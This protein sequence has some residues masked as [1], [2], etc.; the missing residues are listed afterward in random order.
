MVHGDVLLASSFVSYVGPFNK[1]FRDM[2]INDNFLKFFKDNDIPMSPKCDPLDILCDAAEVAQWNNEK[3][4]SDRVSTENGAI[5]TNSDRYSLIIDPQLQG[6][7]WLKEREKTNDLRVTRLSNPKMVKILEAAIE[8]GNP[9]MI[10]NLE[11]NIDAVIQP[12]YARAIIKRGKSKYIKMG[13]KELSLHNDFNLYLHTKLQS[14]HY[15]PEIQAECTLI[16]FTVTE[17]GLEDQLLAL[18]VKKE[19]PDLA[20]QKD[21]LIQDL[22]GY[23]IKL[24]NLQASLLK[25]LADQKGDILDDIALIESLEDA[26]KVSTE[27]TEKVAIAEVIQAQILE[28]SE[29]YRPAAN[30]GALVFFLMNE[31]N[32][33]HSFYRFS[34]DSFVIV[35]NRAIDIVAD[36]LNP[37]KQKKLDED[38]EEKAEGEEGAEAEAEAEEEEEE[39]EEQEMTPRTL[40]KRV[41]MILESI[42]FEGFS[43]TR[44]GTFEAHK[45]VVATMLTL[46]INVR[47][48]LIKENEVVALIKKEVALEP[49]PMPDNLG[50]F[51]PEAI[52]PAV[53]GLQSVKL[54]ENLVSSMESESLQWKKWYGDEKAE[55]AELP[56]SFKDIS[57]FHRILLLRALRPDRLN[58]A[59]TQYVTES[60]GIDYIEQPSFDMQIVYDEMSV[61]TP[62]FFVLFPGVDPTNDVE[63]VGAKYGKKADDQTFT[64]IS[65]GQGQEQIALNALKSAATN[66]N[67]LMIQNVHLMTD[68]M[69]EFERA[70]EVAVD[71]DPH[72]DFRCF[73]SSEPPGLPQQ[74]II[75]E[76]ILQNSIKVSNQAPQDLKANLRR[77]MSKFDEE[78]YE[79]AKTHKYVEFKAIIFGLIMFHALILGRRK[80]GSQG[81]SKFYSFNDGDLTICGDVLHNYLAKYEKVPY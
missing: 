7:T 52:W 15:P 69:R 14:P 8:A 53:N 29:Q 73:I 19:R 51:I 62:A 59:L 27:T 35:V 55:L 22:N 56:K 6:I 42:T 57:L 2:I 80:F 34:L 65:M 68:W 50:K 20:A 3:L 63:R 44:R 32:K 54:F 41:E 12:V 47:K 1:S 37:K 77:A 43:Y 38:G 74:E 75:P 48:G 58:G 21:Q 17:S 4:P 60:L 66:G 61:K 39:E 18:V 31:L 24:S 40:A 76:S 49:P 45:L 46:R 5:L 72:V 33:I 26:K 10:E 81:W 30:R 13:D 64:N 9:V 36:R 25:Q 28:T 11:N 67:W 70:L 78:Y 71:E 23:K 79:K 16:N